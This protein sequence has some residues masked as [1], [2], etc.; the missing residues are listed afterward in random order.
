MWAVIDDATGSIVVGGLSAAATAVGA[1]AL[2]RNKRTDV[3]QST[4]A[5]L[6]TE[7]RAELTALKIEVAALRAENAELRQYIQK[8]SEGDAP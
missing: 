8:L 6:V 4:A 3:N 7:M 5:W 1:W 2:I